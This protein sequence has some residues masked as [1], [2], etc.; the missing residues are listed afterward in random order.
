VLS[1]D[2]GHREN[3]GRRSPASGDVHAETHLSSGP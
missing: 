1:K 3:I 2:V